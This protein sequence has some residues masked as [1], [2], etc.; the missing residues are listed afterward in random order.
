MQHAWRRLEMSTIF[1]G[2]PER[3]ILLGSKMRTG[4]IL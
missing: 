4:Q 1:I 3:N 2:T